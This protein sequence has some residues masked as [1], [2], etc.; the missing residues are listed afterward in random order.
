MVR[1]SSLRE[2]IDDYKEFL[3]KSVRGFMYW[4]VKFYGYLVGAFLLAFDFLADFHPI[5]RWLNLINY[6]VAMNKYY[7]E[8]ELENARNRLKEL[9]NKLRR[10]RG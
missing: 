6:E 5:T 9:R 4:Y 1:R 3:R 7:R 8:Q 10:V 2:Y